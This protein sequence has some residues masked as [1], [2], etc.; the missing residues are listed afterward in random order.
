MSRASKRRRR[1]REPSRRDV[2]KN[3]TRIIKKEFREKKIAEKRVEAL[4]RIQKELKKGNSRERY[5]CLRLGI[6]G[7]DTPEFF[8]GEFDRLLADPRITDLAV[9][10]EGLITFDATLTFAFEG[11]EYLLGVYHFKIHNVFFL[12]AR[13]LLKEEGYGVDPTYQSGLISSGKVDKSL[14][15]YRYDP[16]EAH[17]TGWFCVGG[18]LDYINDLL[19]KKGEIYH[20]ICILLDSMGHINEG[21]ELLILKNHK[22]IPQDVPDPLK[23]RFLAQEV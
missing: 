18:R 12:I 7:E 19:K 21:G 5:I 3:F 20:F 16:S 2:E 1:G 23:T 15:T 10:E 8:G 6:T 22:R 11:Q 17:P 9:S 4:E 13:R 14:P